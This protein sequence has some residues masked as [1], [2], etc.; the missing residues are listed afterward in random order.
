M[1]DN[2]DYSKYLVQ[3]SWF[4]PDWS[5]IPNII[6]EFY[7]AFE[8]NDETTMQNCWQDL[9]QEFQRAVYEDEFISKDSS[10]AVLDYLSELALSKNV[11]V[12]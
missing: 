11:E 3:P 10:E 9:W 5:A 12:L 1:T 2:K 7:E 6:T 8:I 4:N